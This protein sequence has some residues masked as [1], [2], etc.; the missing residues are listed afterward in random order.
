MF[1]ERIW[2]EGE[3]RTKHYLE[4]HGYKVVYTN[5]SCMGIELDIVSILSIAEQKKKIKK[6]LE[7]KLFLEKDPEK[8]KTLKKTYKG[9]M[10]GL[11][12]L[13]VITEVK[14]RTTDR[15]GKGSEAVTNYKREHVKRGAEFLLTQP[16]FKKM[17]PRFDVSSVDDGII[18]YS[19]DAF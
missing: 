1:N 3:R 9:M 13:L 17:Q 11:K 14:S 18:T 2:K 6:E 4:E 7:E 19:E 15:Y 5:Y 10:K 8:K 12:N 16:E